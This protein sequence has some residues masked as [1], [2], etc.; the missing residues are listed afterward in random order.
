LPEFAILQRSTDHALKQARC[1]ID[2]KTG[3]A[4]TATM[5]AM[6]TKLIHVPR[7]A[8]EDEGEAVPDVNLAEECPIVA[9]PDGYYWTS[10]DGRRAFGPFD[11]TEA[12]RADRD[13][14]DERAPEPGE[15]LQEAEADLGI[16]DW[17]D[18]DTG[19]LAEGLSTPHLVDE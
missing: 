14:D 17:I 8:V 3:F 9:H 11:S 16:S 4:T 18:P 13:R 10:S 19:G 7:P 12:A 2:R 1:L 6:K 5:I 15:T